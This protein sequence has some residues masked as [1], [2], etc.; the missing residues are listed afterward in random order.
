[1]NIRA[2]WLLLVYRPDGSIG[3]AAV[4]MLSDSE[5]LGTGVIA[6]DMNLDVGRR[7]M[8][9]KPL[10]KA[11]PAELAALGRRTRICGVHPDHRWVA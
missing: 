4:Y 8:A 11:T 10:A 9:V 7:V 3:R 5:A 1:M 2:E 6:H